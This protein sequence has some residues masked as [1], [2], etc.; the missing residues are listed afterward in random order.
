MKVP[1]IAPFRLTFYFNGHCWLEHKLTKKGI[2][3]RKEDNAYV[4][5]QD[6]GKAQELSDRMR[7]EDLH[8]TL[9]LIAGRYCPLPVEYN[10]K[11]SWTIHQA[12]YAMD[13]KDER[14]LEPLYENII[15]TAMHTVTPED[16]ANFPGKRFSVLFEGEA[17]S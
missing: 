1:T 16:I 3:Y 2:G 17:G 4:Y 11:Y 14:S 8:R 7:V 10:L 6:Y 9:D 12:E 15:K 5:L 13:I